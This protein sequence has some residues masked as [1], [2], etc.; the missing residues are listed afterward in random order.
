MINKDFSGSCSGSTLTIATTYS[1]NTMCH[2]LWYMWVTL[3]NF[4]NNKELRIIPILQMRKPS[5]KE[6]TCPG[7]RT[8]GAGS[9]N[10]GWVWPW[11]CAPTVSLCCLPS[12]D[13]SW[14]HS[15]TLPCPGT[16]GRAEPGHWA[17]TLG[18]YFLV[19]NPSSTDLLRRLEKVLRLWPQ[20]PH[21]WNGDK[22]SSLFQITVRTQWIRF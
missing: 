12:C 16:G 18:T 11:T 17:Q 1:V 5:L 6:L 10:L 22:I 8:E 21:L 4:L 9:A 15:D 14:E 19:K 3:L 2:I 7:S 20:C 13:L